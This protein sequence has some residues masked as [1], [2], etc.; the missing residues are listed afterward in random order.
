MAKHNRSNSNR[1]R[2]Q[3]RKRN[4]STGADYQRLENRQLMALTAFVDPVTSALIIDQTADDGT[5]L[6]EK[7][8]FS[9]GYSIS[10]GATSLS[11]SDQPHLEIN[12]GNFET[13]LTFTNNDFVDGDVNINLGSGEK[14]FRYDGKGS[15][16]SDMSITGGAADQSAR[17]TP[18]R[19]VGIGGNLSVDLGEGFD[20]TRIYDHTIN[21]S[22]SLVSAGEVQ[23]RDSRVDGWVDSTDPNPDS[24]GI[25][26]F[27]NSSV[28]QGVQFVGSNGISAF[29]LKDSTV[30]GGVDIDLGEGDGNLFGVSSAAVFENST[31]LGDVSLLSRGVSV[32]LDKAEFTNASISGN[33][34]VDLNDG[35]NELVVDGGS[36]GTGSSFT[37][38][39]GDH[40]DTVDYAA[41]NG[42]VNLVVDLNDDDDSMTLTSGQFESIDIKFAGAMHLQDDY[43]ENN[44]AGDVDFDVI[45][46]R[47]HGFDLEFIAGDFQM[48]QR[49]QTPKVTL[50]SGGPAGDRMIK[51]RVNGMMSAELFNGFGDVSINML[52]NSSTEL[53]FFLLDDV[54]GDLTLDL[55]EG[56]RVL[57][58]NSDSPLDVYGNTFIS[59]GSGSQ[60]LI[61]FG[62]D[63]LGDVEIDL[64]TGHDVMTN[65]YTIDVEGRMIVRGT[66]YMDTAGFDFDHDRLT[67][68]GNLVFDGRGDDFE[69]N[70]SMVNLV[71]Q[72][73]FIFFGSDLN[74]SLTF[75]HA[76]VGGNVYI[77]FE[78]GDPSGATFPGEQLIAIREIDFGGNLN[79]L[80]TAQLEVNDYIQIGFANQTANPRIGGNVF[81][82]VG[83][84]EE[85]HAIIYATVEG[86][87]FVYRGQ[88]PTTINR[89]ELMLD[90]PDTRTNIVLGEQADQVELKEGMRVK[91]LRVDFGGNMA[92]ALVN[93]VAQSGQ[94]SAF[95][96][97]FLN[98]LGFSIFGNANVD[99]THV[100]QLDDDGAGFAELI[101]VE[102]G[103]EFV[104]RGQ[105]AGT[106]SI[107]T[108]LQTV[109]DDFAITQFSVTAGISFQM[110]DQSDTDIAMVISNPME[111]SLRAQLGDGDREFKI[112]NFVESG[113]TPVGRSTRI[114]A[115]EGSQTVNLADNV[116]EEATSYGST[117]L[118][119]IDLG[120]GNDTLEHGLDVNIGGAFVLSGVN[121]Y[122]NHA[123]VNV[124]FNMTVDNKQEFQMTTMANFGSINV[125]GN[126][127]YLG[128][129]A[130]DVL[131]LND[132]VAVDGITFINLGRGATG[133][134]LRQIAT[135]GD[136]NFNRLTVLAGDATR[137]N[138]LNT[139]D[140]MF[141]ANGF[142][143]NFNNDSFNEISVSGTVAAGEVTIR[144]GSASDEVSFGVNADHADV[145]INTF[146]G[147]DLVV[148]D[149]A[150]DAT[151]LTIN[152][153]DDFDQ[154]FS[155]FAGAEPFELDLL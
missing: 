110:A 35:E 16:G 116:N 149:D 63:F 150:T 28:M 89:L 22:V 17:L 34:H 117:F 15:I 25:L 125:D 21:G 94:K 86:N 3:R 30:F 75:D 119:T 130:I 134:T 147:D 146:G 108:M 153:G 47:L 61:Y 145:A 67:T 93:D 54:A 42:A 44:I 97:R 7:S 50:T 120:D 64:G 91:D 109:D 98:Y 5:V 70:I 136:S 82:N 66:N 112:Y 72:S 148:L 85:N 43:F 20:A 87:Q 53:E 104:G 11:F 131:E 55:G 31:V 71:A 127:T 62:G 155:D 123:D 132:E 49:L 100:V 14:T 73:Q 95:N 141:V 69:M 126:L 77:N 57:D 79:V 46:Q 32:A 121:Q 52:D 2:R 96:S 36:F 76:S 114:V 105:A 111:G 90:A 6:V 37:Y 45:L 154:F 139:S 56:D 144:G 1:S 40:V 24:S 48:T 78:S 118:T 13:D 59:A 81:I 106:E 101:A 19:G 151:S 74:D 124:G 68:A 102:S 26:S 83:A 129:D 23:F 12:L 107:W 33:I 58:F 84:G 88:T 92:D 9:G 135:I 115:G 133:S 10:D 27:D 4:F 39:G 137:G 140:E 99:N 8:S 122:E 113:E 128:T 60:E 138:V 103:V 152:F 143:V 29:G 51:F 142:V 65:H 80:S 41:G 38:L 18:S